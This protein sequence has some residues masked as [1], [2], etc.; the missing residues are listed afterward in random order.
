M[1]GDTLVFLASEST[2]FPAINAITDGAVF[3]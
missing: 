2:P 3:A 1:T